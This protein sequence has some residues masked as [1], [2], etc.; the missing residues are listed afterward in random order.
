MALANADGIDLSGMSEPQ[1]QAR[2]A[3]YARET[4]QAP[5]HVGRELRLARQARDQA[6]ERMM[7]A[8]R[9]SGIGADP[10]AQARHRAAGAQWAAVRDRAA[11]AAALY[12]SAMETRADWHR[13]ADPTLRVAKAAYLEET[14]RDPWSRREPLRSMEPEPEIDGTDEEVLAA[15]GL[16]VDAPEVSDHPERAA[17]Q[18]REHQARLDELAATPE[19]SADPDCEPAEAWGREAARQR[20]AVMQPAQP[21]VRPSQRVLEPEMEAG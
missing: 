6:A 17:A 10:A 15:L 18:A 13:I 9:E 2:R 3:Q 20:E 16:T 8:R 12:E 21:M 5:A 1:L 4:S 19:P 14:R 11:A 7:R